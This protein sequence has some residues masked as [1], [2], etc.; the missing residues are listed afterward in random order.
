MIFISFLEDP[1]SSWWI[2]EKIPGSS[3]NISLEAPVEKDLIFDYWILNEDKE[4]GSES[5]NP[6]VVQ[7]EDLLPPTL[8]PQPEN[9]SQ[10]QLEPEE[11]TEPVLEEPFPLT[12]ENP[13]KE[14]TSSSNLPP[15]S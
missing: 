8:T 12:P 7:P 9:S 3:F 4:E 15:E 10:V 1:G 6:P 14:S 11:T 5:L 2:S 13:A